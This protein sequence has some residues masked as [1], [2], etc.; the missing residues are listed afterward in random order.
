MA[1]QDNDDLHHVVTDVLPLPGP[2]GA[3][4]PRRGRVVELPGG[5]ALVLVTDGIGQSL[6]RRP[7]HGGA[8]VGGGPPSAGPSGDLSPLALAGGGRLQPAA[9]C[10]DDRT[11]LVAWPR[12]RRL[13][14]LGAR[15]PLPPLLPFAG[16]AAPLAR[17]A[18]LAAGSA[19]CRLSGRLLNWP[20]RLG[21]PPCW[22]GY[23]PGRG[24]G[25]F[26]FDQAAGKAIADELVS[27]LGAPFT[28]AARCSN[29]EHADACPVVEAQPEVA[30]GRV[31][32]EVLGEEA[33]ERVE[34]GVGRE[35]V[36]PPQPDPALDQEQ[37]PES[38]QVPDR[39]VQER[40]LERPWQVSPSRSGAG[41]SPGC[42]P[43]RTGR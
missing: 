25:P 38:G 29:D 34:G 12:A 24:H 42:S 11:I 35:Q 22:R 8:G 32:A 10:Q 28:A 5:A 20:D 2:L 16:A 31:D 1:A 27:G 18:P 15:L 36:A 23:R 33:T 17:P 41:T 4:D 40:G 21:R 7:D 6:A 3:R 9:G 19:A 37:K 43:A 13:V 14:P 30:V 39:L 26:H